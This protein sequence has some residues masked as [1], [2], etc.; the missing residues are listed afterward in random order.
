MLT[1]AGGAPPSGM[2]EILKDKIGQSKD[3]KNISVCV[4]PLIGEEQV[5]E[6]GP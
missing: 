5:I 4:P 1:K 2:Q 6:L 3:L